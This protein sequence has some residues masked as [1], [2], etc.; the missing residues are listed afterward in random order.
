MKKIY[1]YTV[2]VILLVLLYTPSY[3]QI[4]RELGEFM[5]L[6]DD[7]ILLDD[8]E[9]YSETNC[10]GVE[11]L[12]DIS[13][14]YNI[15]TALY[16]HNLI[17]AAREKALNDWF[18]KQNN[19]IK[20]EIEKQL[21]QNFSNYSDAQT[22]FYKNLENTNIR[23]NI[24][25]PIDKYIQKVDLRIDSK[26]ISV[27]NLKLLA[28]RENEIKSGIISN[29]NYG[30]LKFNDTPLNQITSLSQLELLRKSEIEVF[31]N[32]HWPYVQD[33]NIL[34]KLGEI[35][36]NNQDIL[37][38]L[39]DL[40]I[41]YYNSFDRWERLDLMQLYL[42]HV[43]VSY[44]LAYNPISPIDY[45]TPNYLENYAIG[46]A[47]PYKSPFHPDACPPIRMYIGGRIGWVEKPND[48]CNTAAIISRQEII[49]E[50]LASMSNDAF[51]ASNAIIRDLNYDINSSGAKWLS[52]HLSESININNYLI[53]NKV[54]NNI[55]TNVVNFT[56]ETINILNSN[57]SDLD[58]FKQFEVVHENYDPTLLSNLPKEEYEARIKHY[59]KRFNE[60]GN[61]EFADYLQSLLPLDG[62]YSNDDYHQLYIT[63][64]NKKAELLWDFIKAAAGQTVDSF[65]PL[66]EMAALEVGGGF[67]LKILQKLPVK[68]LTTPIK[69]I[70]TKLLTPTSSAFS[71]FKH[72]QK[73]GF[74]TYNEF[75][76]YFKYVLNIKKT[77]LGVQVHHLF[78]KRLVKSPEIANFL[79]SNTGNWN[80]IVLTPGE[81]AIFNAQWQKA[82]GY[83]GHAAGW[84]G[85]NSNN[86][87]VEAMK[88]AAREIYKN[89]PEILKALGL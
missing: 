27:R 71:E 64:K 83:E 77:D 4:N 38:R 11:T 84:T 75:S 15:S 14:G 74:K 45:G 66:I 51:L 32:R 36:Y 60:W 40:Q 2:T 29:S 7:P 21:N 10:C 68:Y 31:G 28:L 6:R 17:K 22:A 49:D 86:V 69:N 61:K 50:E 5:I 54:A 26:N 73:F 82:I 70:I 39:K 13:F 47:S 25:I 57:L 52:S 18:N 20:G 30:Y 56:K 3:A 67:A 1:L 85:F 34:I 19:L 87:T 81:H 16:S 63:I 41:N 78:E 12:D 8:F 9:L 59:I 43:K 24:S 65:Q 72:A 58:K 80:S 76:Y 89:Y 79:G 53:S 46:F 33:N 55:P 42:N 37:N 48:V 35:P 62:T 23:N 88:N 44:V